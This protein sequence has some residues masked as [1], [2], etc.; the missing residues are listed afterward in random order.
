M[1]KYLYTIFVSIVLLNPA[2]NNIEVN[3]RF[4]QAKS[5]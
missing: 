3:P 4:N 5:M 1:T 2:S